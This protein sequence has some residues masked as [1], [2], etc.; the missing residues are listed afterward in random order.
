MW[1]H[2]VCLARATDSLWSLVHI[3][4]YWIA[5][6]QPRSSPSQNSWKLLAWGMERGSEKQVQGSPGCPHP[7]S[8]QR[9]C[10]QCFSLSCPQA[11]WQQ[12]AVSGA[13][14]QE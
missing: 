8:Y 9:Y 12:L 14:P 3:N 7:S 5:P 10:P 2:T 6:L 11:E 4:Q 1:T 13:H